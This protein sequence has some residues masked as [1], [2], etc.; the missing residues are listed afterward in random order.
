[1]DGENVQVDSFL[2][3][4]IEVTNM[5]WQACVEAGK[6]SARDGPA[7]HPVVGISLEE[8][9]AFCAWAGGRLPTPGEY[10]ASTAGGPWPWGEDTPSCA[11]AVGRGCD[12]PLPA[13]AAPLGA[14][15]DGAFDLA[16]NAWEWLADGTLVGGGADSGSESLG[17]RGLIVP[18][19]D[20]GPPHPWAGVRCAY[21]L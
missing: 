16:G 20:D 14:S 2:L 12:G 11:H 7:R 19:P 15:A 18:D 8:A 21:A 1:M 13:G 6:C 4:R 9:T 3:D 5:R 17:R 10:R